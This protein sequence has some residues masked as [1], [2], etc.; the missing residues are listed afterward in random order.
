MDDLL[1]FV[2]AQLDADVQVALAVFRS[3][4]R[5]DGSKIMSIDPPGFP[6]L[7]VAEVI[8]TPTAEHIARW[9]GQRVLAEVEA[10]RRIL[11]LHIGAHDCTEI[12]TG[13]YPDDWPADAGWGK[14]GERW[15]HAANEHF[16]ADQPCPTVRLLAQ[17][18]AG[19]DGW[20]EEW[21]A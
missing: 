15:A 16:E 12:H 10:K 7:P 11:D 5:A 21:R 4:V 1:A 9:S 18:Y 3:R 17:P 6:D 2:R 8:D 13:V 20:R 19:R 14:A